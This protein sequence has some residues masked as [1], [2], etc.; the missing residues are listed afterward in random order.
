[1]SSEQ[2]VNLVQDYVTLI[3]SIESLRPHEFLSKCADIL[4]QLYT[5]GRNIPEIDLPDSDETE[6]DV[7]NPMG[8]IGK[9]LGRYDWYALVFDPVF[10]E[11]VVRTTLSD[12]LGDIYCD[13]K[14]SLTQFEIGT[15]DSQKHALWEWKFGINGHT[16]NHI[17]NA[18]R[19]IHLL[20]NNHMDRDFVSSDDDR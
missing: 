1:M 4:P 5:T 19:V 3:E 2:F 8:D 6:F 13:L 9:L 10:E 17:V 18:L 16:G 15:S 12:D 7:K 20:I 11:N 14:S